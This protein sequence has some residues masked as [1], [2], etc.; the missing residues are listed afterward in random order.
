[1]WTFK[2]I[3]KTD[4]SPKPDPFF[5]QAVP[6]AASHLRAALQFRLRVRATS[7]PTALGLMDIAEPSGGC[8]RGDIEDRGTPQG[9]ALWA[10]VLSPNA[11]SEAPQSPA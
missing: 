1:M 11:A 4:S 9:A 3:L 6:T 7:S 8:T 5:P 10:F 2:I